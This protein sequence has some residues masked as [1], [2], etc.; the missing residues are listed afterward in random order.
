MPSCRR[1]SRGKKSDP[2]GRTPPLRALPFDRPSSGRE[3][4]AREA[5]AGWWHALGRLAALGAAGRR[6]VARAGL[7]IVGHMPFEQP[8]SQFLAEQAGPV[9][10][11]A[12]GDELVLFGR[13]QHALKDVGGRGQPLL[14]QLFPRVIQGRNRRSHRSASRRSDRSRASF[15]PLHATTP[16]A[17]QK[18][19][20]T[21]VFALAG[22][23]LAD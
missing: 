2:T 15:I 18:R 7:G 10:A 20:C 22:A 14:P 8:G 9:L 4:P 6:G 19:N 12:E 13:G 3:L 23:V 11:L 21:P 17:A 1:W 5:A 16:A